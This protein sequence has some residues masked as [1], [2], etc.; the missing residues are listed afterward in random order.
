MLKSNQSVNNELNLDGE[1]AIK[2]G[3]LSVV[4]QKTYTI[5]IIHS[6]STAIVNL[7]IMRI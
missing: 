3:V 2:E 4:Q 7:L 6:W 5:K 1:L